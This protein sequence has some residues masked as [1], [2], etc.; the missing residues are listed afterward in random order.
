VPAEQRL[1]LGWRYESSEA[2][3][4]C[5]I[6][7]KGNPGVPSVLLKL[8]LAARISS[9]LAAGG[10]CVTLKL[11]TFSFAKPLTDRLRLQKT[12]LSLPPRDSKATYA[13][14]RSPQ[15]AWR[16][17]LTPVGL[18]PRWPGKAKGERQPAGWSWGPQR[19]QPLQKN[20]GRGRG[21]QPAV[22]RRRSSRPDGRSLGEMSTSLTP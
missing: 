15:R 10:G 12:S 17:L 19:V 4:A 8:P 21:N 11:Q 18:E 3:S 2:E 6:L 9:T 16:F 5:K 22:C 20:G 13:P 1:T 14:L 7:G